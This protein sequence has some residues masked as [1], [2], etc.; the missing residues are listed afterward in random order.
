MYETICNIQK[1]WTGPFP[2]SLNSYVSKTKQNKKTSRDCKKLPRVHFIGCQ[3]VK[4]FLPKNFLKFCHKLIVRLWVFKI[5]QNLSFWVLSQFD[6]E[7]CYNLS[8]LILSQFRFF[9]F[10]AIWVFEFVVIWFF[11]FVAIW[12]VTIE[13]WV[14]SQFDFLRC[15]PIWVFVFC[16]NSSFWVLSEFEF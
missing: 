13:F 7:F 3:G 2:M 5:C 8:F 9:S 16:Y 10:V 15:V 1:P 11:S 14:W 12:V 6:L 4:L